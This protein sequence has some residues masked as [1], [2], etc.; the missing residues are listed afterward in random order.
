MGWAPSAGLFELGLT[1]GSSNGTF[2]DRRHKT[3]QPLMW[4]VEQ[5]GVIQITFNVGSGSLA[6]VGQTGEASMKRLGYLVMLMAL[7]SSAQAGNTFSFVVGGHRV[8]I[9]APR[10]CRFASCVSLSFPGIYQA[11][12]KRDRYDDTGVAT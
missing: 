7:S 2:C 9:D 8:N 5:E 11:H 10:N 1:L 4:P 6:F 3:R 12:R